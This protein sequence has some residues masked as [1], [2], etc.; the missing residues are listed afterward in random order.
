MLYRY[1]KELKNLKIIMKIEIFPSNLI[2]NFLLIFI[3]HRFLFDKFIIMSSLNWVLITIWLIN[4]IGETF[5]L[6]YL[7][8]S[9]MFW[10]SKIPL[11]RKNLI[12]WSG[13]IMKSTWRHGNKVK[14]AFL[15]L[16]LACEKWMKQDTCIIDAEW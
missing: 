7:I 6:T 16:M 1:L 8:I 15:L 14:L 2:Q 13:N 5:M 12:K 11:F 9:P 4:C 10:G 3:L